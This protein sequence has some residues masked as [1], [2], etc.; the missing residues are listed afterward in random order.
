MMHLR[1]V[2]VVGSVP[3]KDQLAEINDGVDII[4]ATPGRIEDFI[5]TGKLSLNN[6]RF[7]ILDEAVSM[8]NGCCLV[9]CLG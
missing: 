2:L 5:S 8:R 1:N 3:I 7:Y 4:T 6:V 9:L